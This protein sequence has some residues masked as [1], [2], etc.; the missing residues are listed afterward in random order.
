[1]IRKLLLLFLLI[2]CCG[3]ELATSQISYFNDPYG[4]RGS[5]W[6]VT[7][8]G[9]RYDVLKIKSPDKEGEA[10]IVLSEDQLGEL[11]VKVGEL[12]R[13]RN[14]LKNEG[15]QVL[16]NLQ[17]GDAQVRTLYAQIN[18]VKVKVL[19]VEQNK[20][21][22]PKSEHQVCIDECYGDFNRAL[23]KLRRAP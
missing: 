6:K 2:S 14:P 20:A 5:F 13:S 8:E 9:K 7:Y 4:N 21:G 11:E 12:K 1:M 15:F 10:D 17:A 22:S 23:Q 19:Q 18:G 3:A 16:W